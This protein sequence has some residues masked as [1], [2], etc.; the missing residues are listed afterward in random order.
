MLRALRGPSIGL[1]RPYDGLRGLVIDLTGP[2]FHLLF[3]HERTFVGL[4]GPQTAYRALRQFTRLSDG[5]QGL[6]DSLMG[7]HPTYGAL[8]RPSGPA[9]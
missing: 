1:R 6:H 5:F 3:R 2:S 9:G 8:R 7:P 4:R